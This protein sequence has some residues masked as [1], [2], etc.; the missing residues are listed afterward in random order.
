MHENVIT[1]PIIWVNLKKKKSK[2]SLKL[3][4]GQIEETHKMPWAIAS[5]IGAV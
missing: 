1:K 5:V 3:L 2:I 4:V